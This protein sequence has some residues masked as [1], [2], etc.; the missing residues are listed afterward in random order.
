MLRLLGISGAL[1]AGC[2]VAAAAPG[3]RPT[4]ARIE[5]SG[6]ATVL[7]VA[8]PDYRKTVQRQPKG[9]ASEAAWY[10][11][12]FGITVAE[13]A[14][15][16]AEQ[17]ALVN[18]LNRLG[19]LLPK[20]EA[21]NYSGSRMV[22]VPDWGYVYYFKRDPAATLAKYTRHPRFKAAQARYTDEELAALIKPW[23]D[24]FTEAGI[25]GGYGSDATLGTAE[26]MMSVTE[27]E[28]RALAASKGWGPLPDPIRLGFAKELS[29]PAVDPRAASYFRAFASDTR[30][31]V[32]QLTAGFSGRI[33]LRDGCLRVAAKD[34]KGPLAYFHRE[35]GIGVDGQGYLALIDRRTGKPGGRIGEMFSWGGPN[36]L[37][38]DMPGLAELKAR[39]GEGPVAHVGNPE[40]KAAFDLRYSRN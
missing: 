33:E 15:R 18:E 37:R 4:G 34:G 25:I 24:R 12:E 20:V 17:Q 26:F 30:S 14:K 21:G 28:Y 39:C 38:D 2:T 9:P 22:H 1:I 23:A 19:G 10:A 27:A 8:V 31:T 6:Y 32:I 3:F 5:P 11:A 35:T 16:Q 29:A 7:N 13:A 36:H 40:S